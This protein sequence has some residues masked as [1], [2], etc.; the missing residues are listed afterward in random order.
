M[1]APPIEHIFVRSRDLNEVISRVFD[2]CGK[3]LLFLR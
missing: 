1:R 3:G 2:L